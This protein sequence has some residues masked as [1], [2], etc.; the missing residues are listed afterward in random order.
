MK[1]T[2]NTSHS[3]AGYLSL[4][5]YPVSLKKERN[6]QIE[7]NR[8]ETI[9][10]LLFTTGSAEKEEETKQ[11]NTHRYTHKWYLKDFQRL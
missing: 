9:A 3:L 5:L 2:D 1:Q 4:S 10:A 8:H 6:F 11:T 7:S